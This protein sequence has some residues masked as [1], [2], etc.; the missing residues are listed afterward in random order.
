MQRITS[1]LLSAIATTVAVTAIAP[2][3]TAFTGTHDGW[4]YFQDSAYDSTGGRAKFEMFGIAYKQ[5]GDTISIAINSNMGL[6]GSAVAQS[7]DGN[8]GY[9]DLMLNFGDTQYGIRFAGANDSG[10]SGTGVFENITTTD[11]TAANDGWSSFESYANSVGSNATHFG[12]ERDAAFFAN[13]AHRQSGN[14]LA[15]GDW[16]GGL[17]TLGMGELLDFG[18]AFGGAEIGTETFG[19]SFRRT[20]EMVGD[21]TLALLLECINDGLALDGS[22]M[23]SE[24]EIEDPTGVPEPAGVVG[25]LGAVIFGGSKLRRHDAEA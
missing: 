17:T 2:V 12:D 5:D 9:G 7:A 20:E 13:D 18:A 23:A 16:V 14:V 1:T 11:V 6:G 10:V 22:L 19:F 24:P 25:L 8:T 21:F 3:A 15:S 4:T